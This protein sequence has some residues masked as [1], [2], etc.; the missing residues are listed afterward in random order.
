MKR[1]EFMTLVGGAAAIWPLA[2]PAQPI[3]KLPKVG[4]LWHAASAEEEAIGL[5]ALTRGFSD[6]GY[7]EGKTIALHHRFPAELTQRFESLSA[8]LVAIPV[9]VLVAVTQ[10]AALAAQRATTRIPIVFILVPEPVGSK[11]INSLARPGGN[12]TGLTNIAA[13]LTAKRV[14]LLKEAFPRM[15]RVTLLV[16]PNDQQAMHRFIDEAKI[17]ATA[18]GLDVQPLEVR[19]LGEFEQAFDSMAD[20]RSEGVITTPNGLFYLGRVLAGQLA[21]KRRLPLMVQNRETLEDGALM[22]Y[23]PDIQVLFRRAA[24]YVD[25]IL[26]G[27][28]PADLPVEVPT[29]F[30]FFIN[31]KTAKALGLTL[32]ESLLLRADEAIE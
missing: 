9:D 6:L 15:K 28:K 27:E 24:V 18:L 3:K 19:S 14:Q 4:V 32:P 7:I 23:G 10:P 11:L 16:N 12:I 26:K 31:L 5:S 13:E 2:A 25:K 1:R 17:A 21:V 29:K 30:Q 8:E 20:S 22:A